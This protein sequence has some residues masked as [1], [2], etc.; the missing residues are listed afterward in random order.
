MQVDRRDGAAAHGVGGSIVDG[1][2]TNANEHAPVLQSLGPSVQ[3]RHG[4]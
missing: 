4:F 3:T 2:L 1:E